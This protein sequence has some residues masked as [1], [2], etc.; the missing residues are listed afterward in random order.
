MSES[1]IPIMDLVEKWLSYD[2]DPKTRKQI[3]DLRD[4]NDVEQLEK[5]LRNPIE[6][7][8]AGLR[9]T[10]EAGFSR[11]NNVTV[12]QASQGLAIYVKKNIDSAENKGVV[13]G[14]DHRHNSET[15]AQLAAAVFL[16][17][18]F[19]VYYLGG[20]SITPLVPFSV[21]KLAAACGVMVTASHNP[22]DDNGYKVYWDNGAQIIPPHDTGI[23]QCIKENQTITIWDTESY[24]THSNVVNMKEELIDAYF[25]SA[26]SLVLDKQ[27]IADMK[28]NYVYTAMH[29]V[30][31]PY[32][33][34]ILQTLGMKPYIPVESQVEPDPDF[35]TVSFPN[36][37]EKGALDMAKA[38]ADKAGATLVLASDPDADRFAAAEKQAD[39]SWYVFSGDQLGTLLAYYALILAKSKDIPADKLAMVN[40][41]VSS[42]MLESMAKH[43]G[44]R[45]EDT[46]TGFK[47]MSNELV[48]IRNNEGLIPAFAYEEAIGY[49]INPEVLDKD[50]V[51]A[52]ACFVQLAVH[53]DNKGLN[54]KD[55]LESLYSKYGYFVSDNYYYICYDNDKINAIFDRIRYGSS[56]PSLQADLFPRTNF[57]YTDSGKTL[58]YPMEIG[59]SPVTYIRDL[60]IGFEVE[61]LDSLTLAS[62]NQQINV[63]PGQYY[64]KFLVSPESQMITF[65]TANNGRVTIRTSGTEPKIKYYI[66]MNG[67]NDEKN[68]VQ[69]NLK[70]LAES[71]GRDLLEATKNELV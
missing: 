41:T 64:P 14:H 62:N 40:S 16:S 42:R 9:S 3:E 6:F 36:P 71:V 23:A 60:T 44:F 39:G 49:L 19:K 25:E 24:K 58:R 70:A 63:S 59:G 56:H 48:N 37:E 50:G 13:I 4:K 35:P 27:S 11:M 10:M 5:L 52:M 1:Q 34:R 51:T 32:C 26:K 57:F 67:S 33:S 43:E 46:L 61:Q 7:G 12:I 31:A 2:K 18:G 29:G 28:I 68:L 38:A 55:L 8:T 20:L 54:T 66:E 47:W 30:G 53:M 45:Y 65:E 22:K 69:E 21:K 17:Q 15:F